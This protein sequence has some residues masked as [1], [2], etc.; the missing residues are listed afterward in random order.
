MNMPRSYSLVYQYFMVG[1]IMS[2]LYGT[3]L[4]STYLYYTILATM[5]IGSYFMITDKV[6]ILEIGC[7]FAHACIHI[8]MTYNDEMFVSNIWLDLILHFVTSLLTLYR[9]VVTQ[10]ATG[11]CKLY[12]LAIVIGSFITL[13]PT[14][15]SDWIAK[16]SSWN[17]LFSTVSVCNFSVVNIFKEKLF[18]KRLIFEYVF[19][20]F[21]F[22]ALVYDLIP[23]YVFQTS[24]YVET[25]F[26]SCLLISYFVNKEKSSKLKNI[27]FSVKVD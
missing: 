13:I 26:A 25:Y 15:N 12:L 19:T 21:L 7:V 11:Y 17:Y 2:T 8:N 24:R 23:V 18:S 1:M 14:F 10:S 6:S 20:L 5:A 3:S 9:V 4:I 16:Q 22:V 27:P